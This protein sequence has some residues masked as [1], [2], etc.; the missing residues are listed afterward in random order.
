MSGLSLT[1]VSESEIEKIHSKTLDVFEQVGIK[2]GH[3]EALQKLKKAGATKVRNLKIINGQAI[4]IPANAVSALNKVNGVAHLSDD[5]VVTIAKRGGNKPPKPPPE[6][7]PDLL[8]ESPWQT[9]TRHTFER[10]SPP[11]RK[12]DPSDPETCRAS[13]GADHSWPQNLW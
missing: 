8:T 9:R 13:A 11:P 5:S 7:T 12:H 6:P 2:V 3:P 4:S 1:V 10:T